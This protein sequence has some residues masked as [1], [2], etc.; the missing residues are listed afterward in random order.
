MGGTTGR[1]QG[2]VGQLACVVAFVGTIH[3]EV[4]RSTGRPETAG[5]VAFLRARRA[6]ARSCSMRAARS[7][8]LAIDK[9]QVDRNSLSTR[10]HQLLLCPGA[11]RSRGHRAYGGVSRVARRESQMNLNQGRHSK[12]GPCG[13]GGF[14]RVFADDD[15]LSRL[16]PRAVRLDGPLP[17]GPSQAPIPIRRDSR[18]RRDQSLVLDARREHVRHQDVDDGETLCRDES[19]GQR[20]SAPG[21]SAPDSPNRPGAR[22]ACRSCHP[23]SSQAPAG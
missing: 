18:I 17:R 15:D 4:N 5:A 12:L 23:P 22:G 7:S 13:G 11:R 21:S 2:R 6:P 16:D 14:G 9:G 19:P 8:F 1:S 20:T 3:D 10:A